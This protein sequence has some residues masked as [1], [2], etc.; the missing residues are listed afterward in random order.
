MTLE[1]IK[2]IA[3]L[4]SMNY[5]PQTELQCQM[6]M[7]GCVEKIVKKHC[8]LTECKEM[9]EKQRA[10]VVARCARYR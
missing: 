8:E 6:T 10:A 2:T 4:C 9:T 5:H 7:I 3:L 1:I